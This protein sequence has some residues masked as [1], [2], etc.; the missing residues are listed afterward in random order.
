MQDDEISLTLER[1][2]KQHSGLFTVS[3]TGRAVFREYT[4]LRNLAAYMA[5]PDAPKPPR[6]LRELVRLVDPEVLALVAVHAL[7]NAIDAEWDFTDRALRMK[8][9]LK[10]GED[11][12]GEIE[13][14]TL[15]ERDRKEHRRVVKARNRHLALWHHR[16]QKWPPSLLVHAGAWLYDCALRCDLFEEEKRQ[17]GRSGSW[18][19]LPKISDRRQAEFDEIYTKLSLARPYYLPHDKPPPD[20]T[21]FRTEYGPNRLPATF[22]R[23]KHPDTVKAVQATFE[24][25][26]MTRHA[27][28]VNIIQRVPWVI[29]DRMLPI[30]EALATEIAADEA[31]NPKANAKQAHKNLEVDI[32]RG[33]TSLLVDHFG[34]HIAATFVGG[35]TQLRISASTARTTSALSS[36]SQMGSRLARTR[37]GWKLP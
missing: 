37:A 30:V 9:L 28:G 16:T 34:Y 2:K 35:F 11:L 29:N 36:S 27:S 19:W 26:R 13:M 3:P 33:P 4:L 31:K 10:I 14:I 20:W 21:S 25:G 12:R 7:I 5:G 32:E 6:K 8:L 1:H 22:V 17:V 23:A 15:R 24:N 18:V